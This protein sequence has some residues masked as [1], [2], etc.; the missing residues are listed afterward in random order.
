[1]LSLLCRALHSY[2]C[3]WSR[4]HGAREQAVPNAGGDHHC[5]GSRPAVQSSPSPA[6][7]CV[8]EARDSQAFCSG[9]PV[10]DRERRGGRRKAPAG[11]AA[12][13]GS[14]QGWARRCRP[15]W[16]SARRWVQGA[17]MSNSL[18]GRW[19]QI[20]LFPHLIREAQSTG[21]FIP[22]SPAVLS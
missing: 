17:G 3:C 10:T 11:P 18:L 16:P 22:F 12:A 6:T 13:P 1:M 8:P 5:P 9:V 20:W 19:R 21:L 4:R 15:A 14:T 7:P 2:R